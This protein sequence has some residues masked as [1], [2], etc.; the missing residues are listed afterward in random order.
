MLTGVDSDA[1]VQVI[2][3]TTT[4]GL[5]SYMV[6]GFEFSQSEH[7]PG[8]I[9]VAAMEAMTLPHTHLV[10]KYSNNIYIERWYERHNSLLY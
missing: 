1:T 2:Q 6:D 5:R 3:C 10:F 7:I 8:L 4:A 9:H